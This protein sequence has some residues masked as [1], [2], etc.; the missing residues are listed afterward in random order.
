MARSQ[1]F[2]VVFLGDSSVGKTCLARLFIECEVVEHSMNTIGFDEYVKELELEDG[3]PVKVC[4]VW[5]TWVNLCTDCS[6]NVYSHL[7]GANN[8][9]LMATPV[10]KQIVLVTMQLKGTYVLL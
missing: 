8:Y 4:V 3:I 7:P 2:K 1:S 6:S 10:S 5:D 9:F